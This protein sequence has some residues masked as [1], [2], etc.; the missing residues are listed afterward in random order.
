MATHIQTP[1]HDL[2]HLRIP[3][4]VPGRQ[5]GVVSVE[6]EPGLDAQRNGQDLLGLYDD[7]DVVKGYPILHAAVSSPQSRTY[8]SLYGWVQITSEAEGVWEMDLYPMFKDVNSPF[9]MWGAEPT[10]V[11]A[12]SR[13][14]G[15]KQL[16]W[17]ARSFLC[18]TPDAAMTK[19]VVPIL[20]FEWGWWLEDYKPSVKL[21]QKLDVSSWN[22]H[23]EL[24]RDSFPDWLF[25]QVHA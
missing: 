6:V 20:A 24:F 17:L 3:F 18:Y 8:A 19:H 9:C 12:P 23:L 10:L 11:D 15:T 22:E 2:Q 21:L 14:S 13:A 5:P 7:L 1:I 25:E 16:D 4:T